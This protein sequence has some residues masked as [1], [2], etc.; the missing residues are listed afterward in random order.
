[1]EGSIRSSGCAEVVSEQPPLAYPA[2]LRALAALR[3]HRAAAAAASAAPAEGPGGDAVRFA[4]GTSARVFRET[5]VDRGATLDPCVLV[6]EFGCGP[7]GVAGMPCSGGRACST[8]R[9][10]P[11]SPAWC[12]SCGWPTTNAAG[13]GGCMSGIAR[14]SRKLRPG[15]VAGARP[16]VGAGLDPLRR[17]AWAAPRRAAGPVAG[18][19]RRRGRVVAPDRRRMREP[20]A[21]WWPARARPAWPWPCRPTTTAPSSGSSTGGRRRSGP[22]GADRARPHVRGAAPAWGDAGTAGPFGYTADSGPAARHPGQ[23]GHP[24]RPAAAG[25][26]LPAPVAGPADG[27]GAGAGRGPRRAR[28]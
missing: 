10:S 18:T 27:R 19:V 9:C 13:T 24:G 4:D 6:V 26:R 2:A 21:S 15:P 3:G 8:L 22:P 12:R 17:A 7:C 23:P 11:A 5:A 28:G 16:G 14:G 20:A 1:M 25:H